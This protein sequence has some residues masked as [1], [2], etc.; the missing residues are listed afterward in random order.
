MVF[1]KF[2]SILVYLEGI[3]ILKNM[4]TLF[5]TLCATEKSVS[6]FYKNKAMPSGYA[7]QCKECVKARA[8][9]REKVLRQDP[10][11]MGKGKN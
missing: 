11:W 1:V 10:E 4:K 8:K 5:C 9:A 6:E 3:L 7:N 2:P